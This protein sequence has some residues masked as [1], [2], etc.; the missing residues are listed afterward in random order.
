M[1]LDRQGA[2]KT[3]FAFLSY[4]CKPFKEIVYIQL[5]VSPYI[6]G[7]SLFGIAPCPPYD[8]AVNIIACHGR[9]IASGN[10][11]FHYHGYNPCCMGGS[12]SGACCRSVTVSRTGNCAGNLIPGSSYIRFYQAVSRVPS[13]GFQENAVVKLVISGDCKLLGAVSGRGYGG[14]R[15]WI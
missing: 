15:I 6:I 1:R 7:I 12:C 10:C 2:I 4:V 5:P 3:H 13:A 11:P 8:E 14:V 9:V